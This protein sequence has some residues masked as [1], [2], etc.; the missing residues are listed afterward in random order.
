MQIQ[1]DVMYIHQNDDENFKT[2]PTPN[3]N[4]SKLN[5]F[6][7]EKKNMTHK[8]TNLGEKMKQKKNENLDFDTKKAKIAISKG[9]LLLILV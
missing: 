8:I 6:D 3:F 4:Q 1:G 7:K 5:K 2:A 9:M